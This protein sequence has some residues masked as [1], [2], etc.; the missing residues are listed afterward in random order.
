[1]FLYCS[2]GSFDFDCSSSFALS[3]VDK[4]TAGTYSFVSVIV[5]I[6]SWSAIGLSVIKHLL[7]QVRIRLISQLINDI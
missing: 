4:V 3:W 5:N 2:F 6:G 1:M 7:D